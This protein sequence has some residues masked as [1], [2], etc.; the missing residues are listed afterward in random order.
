MPALPRRRLPRRLTWSTYCISP[1]S[2]GESTD[3]LRCVHGLREELE[4]VGEV[5][6][7]QQF[8]ALRHDRR[9]LGDHALDVLALGHLLLA[10]RVEQLDRRLAFGIK[11]AR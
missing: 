11:A 9:R 10:G 5:L 7:R 8:E 2:S 3:S 6:L 4:E 1:N